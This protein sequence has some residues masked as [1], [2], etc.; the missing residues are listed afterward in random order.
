MAKIISKCL[1]CQVVY[2]EKESMGAPGGVSHGYCESCHE[3]EM[4][5]GSL[6]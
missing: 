1:G 6:G 4:K 5:K 2:S 3:N